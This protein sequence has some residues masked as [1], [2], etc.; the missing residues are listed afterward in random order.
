MKKPILLIIVF[1]LLLI[2]AGCSGD[3]TP[4]SDDS[5]EVVNI[6]LP[7]FTLEEL[8]TYNG[9]DGN[10]AYVAYEGYVYDVSDLRQWSSGSHGG[11]TAGTDIT[12]ALKTLSPHGPK[13]INLASKVGKLK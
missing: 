2:L 13:N 10:K 6:E 3:K 7:L 11:Y 8:A 4:A 1:S 5:L 12:E 9:K